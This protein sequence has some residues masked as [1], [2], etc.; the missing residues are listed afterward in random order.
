MKWKPQYA[1]RMQDCVFVKILLSHGGTVKVCH[2]MKRN[3]L[4]SFYVCLENLWICYRKYVRFLEWSENSNINFFVRMFVLG[5]GSY[6]RLDRR[7]KLAFLSLLLQIPR[8]KNK[9]NTEHWWVDQHKEQKEKKH[10][11][12]KEQ[13][14][15][16]PNPSGSRHKVRLV[17]TR[18]P[19]IVSIDDVN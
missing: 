8:I 14:N 4:L 1:G 13:S 19:I 16:T 5:L 15:I 10:V 9:I 6:Y 18:L 11:T 7:C 3:N 12:R 2:P 17:A